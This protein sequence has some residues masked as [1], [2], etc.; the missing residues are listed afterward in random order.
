VGLASMMERMAALGGQLQ[1]ESTPGRGT[2]VT[3]TYPYEELSQ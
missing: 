1:V 3:A 2:Q